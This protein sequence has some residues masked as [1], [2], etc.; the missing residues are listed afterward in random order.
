MEAIAA[1]EFTQVKPI[2]RWNKNTRNKPS[3]TSSITPIPTYYPTTEWPT[4]TPTTEEDKAEWLRK[5]QKYLKNRD[6]VPDSVFE[7]DEAS[8]GK[9]K[10]LWL[11]KQKNKKNNK[12]SNKS[13]TEEEQNTQDH[14]QDGQ[15]SNP[16]L[17]PTFYDPPLVPTR[18]QKQLEKR[19]QAAQ[20]QNATTVTGDSVA[21]SS[22]P[23]LSLSSIPTISSIPTSIAIQETPTRKQNK[24]AVEQAL[25][26]EEEE[27]KTEQEPSVS[28]TT[29]SRYDSAGSRHSGGTRTPP[30][31][32][33][34]PVAR[35]SPEKDDEDVKED[36]T[37][38]KEKDDEEVK[39]D[40]TDAKV[41]E[42]VKAESEEPEVLETTEEEQEP[43]IMESSEKSNEKN[44]VKAQTTSSTSQKVSLV[45]PIEELEQ[46][47]VVVRDA[48]SP[49]P[50]PVS[51]TPAPVE[52]TQTVKVNFTFTNNRAKKR[53]TPAPT[54]SATTSEPTYILFP[55][56]TPTQFLPTYAPTA[57]WTWAPSV[58]KERTRI[59]DKSLFD[60]RTC[61]SSGDLFFEQ[62]LRTSQESSDSVFFTY[63]I[64]TSEDG[65]IQEAVKEIQLWLMDEVANELLHCPSNSSVMR[66]NEFGTNSG[67]GVLS[68]VYYSKDDRQYAKQCTPTTS[69]ADMCA[70]VSSTLRFEE[71]DPKVKARSK[72]LA[73]IFNQLQSGFDARLDEV[74]ILDLAYLGPDLGYHQPDNTVTVDST[75]PSK[76]DIPASTYAAIGVTS[77]AMFA[78][79]LCLVMRCRVRKER[80]RT[81]ISS[82]APYRDVVASHHEEDSY[83]FTPSGSRK[84]Y[85]R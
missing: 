40:K 10:Q 84:S 68:S 61:S 38:A 49:T 15:D 55:T 27:I 63:G 39:E 69:D 54:P 31:A 32:R 11:E 47:E 17:T 81:T 1:N 85:Y 71:V 75:P 25:L 83:S 76:L 67:K 43:I 58:T 37:D 2:S 45:I 4:Y 19:A 9:K 51:P 26:D 23:S 24:K 12:T 66:S 46:Q 62:E 57:P 16:T 82:V 5:K 29:H 73:V 77:F 30:K 36:E 80:N 56:I 34:P 28:S 59:T 14:Q 18:K 8:V 52:R 42:E 78:L 44:D 6:R 65:D 7:A 13:D 79:L 33:T 64:Q 21:P 22:A 74:N 35:P 50:V 72:V 48:P 3:S 70:I 41:M 60:K 20:N 53:L